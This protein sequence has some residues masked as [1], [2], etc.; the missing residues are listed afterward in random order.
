MELAGAMS[1]DAV[2]NRVICAVRARERLA[3]RQAAPSRAV[4][5]ERRQ[6][7]ALSGTGRDLV[8]PISPPSRTDGDQMKPLRLRAFCPFVRMTVSIDQ[9]GASSLRIAFVSTSAEHPR[10]GGPF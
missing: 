2:A 5:R 10:N 3:A 9:M 1:A 4:R 6:P 7:R 8:V